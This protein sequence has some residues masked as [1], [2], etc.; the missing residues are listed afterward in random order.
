[1]SLALLRIARYPVSDKLVRASSGKLR[2]RKGE[3][4]VLKYG[5]MSMRDNLA[6]ERLHLLFRRE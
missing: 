6:D 1:V 2:D 3:G 5:G 4:Y